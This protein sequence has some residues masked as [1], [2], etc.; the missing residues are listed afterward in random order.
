MKASGLS[1]GNVNASAPRRRPPR[2]VVPAMGLVLA[3]I[4]VA[5]SSPG[6]TKATTTT[7]TTPKV[8]QFVLQPGLGEKLLSAVKLPQAWDGQLELR[9][10]GPVHQ[11]HIRPKHHRPGWQARQSH[12][13]DWIGRR[14]AQAVQ[15]VRQ[16]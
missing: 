8:K 2:F 9:L 5:C 14:G 3:A 7:I 6:A 4:A 11:G 15:Q 10:S 16:L 13:P 1:S 12:D